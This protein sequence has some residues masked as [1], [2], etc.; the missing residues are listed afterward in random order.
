MENR[1]G[2]NERKEA[3][4][5][6]KKAEEVQC[7]LCHHRCSISDGRRGICGVRENKG[8]RLY[9]LVYNT[10]IAEH[11]DPIEKKPLFHFF[12]NSMVYSIGT[13]GCNFRCTHCQNAEISQYP[14]QHQGTIIGEQ[15]NPEQIVRRAMDTGCIS[16]AYTYTEPTIFYELA[17]ETACLAHRKGIKNVFVSNGYLGTEAA[18]QIAPY[19]DAINIDLKSFSEEFYK[20]VCGARLAPVLETIRLMRKLGVWQELTTLIIPGLNDSEHELRDIARFVKSVGTEIPWHVTRFYPAHKLHSH[21]PTPPHTLRRAKEI[22]LEEGLRYVYQGNI[23]GEENTYCFNCGSLVIE[24][25]DFHWVRNLLHD[26][27]CPECRTSIDG[28]GMKITQQ[29]EQQTK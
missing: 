11:I 1:K 6:Q 24:R 27:R 22:G 23:P 25:S 2:P 10:V 26:A 20:K 8:G 17:Y 29:K 4:F 18:H 7:I 9:T 21:P 5:Y 13:V 14:H 12:P 19:L 28:I 16:I 3:L 15:R